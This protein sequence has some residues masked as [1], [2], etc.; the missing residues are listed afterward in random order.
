MILFWYIVREF[1]RY[2]TGTVILSVFLFL[3]FD[4]V[5]RATRFFTVYDATATEVILFYLYQIPTLITQIMPIAG[6]IA[7]VTC[8]LLLAR[9]NEITA[10]RAAGM[11]PFK[12]GLPI[13]VGGILLSLLECV[14]SEFVVP[15]SAA[16]MHYVKEVL[17]EGDSDADMS[18]KTKWLKTPKGFVY[19]DDFN[20]L[21]KVMSGIKII[22]TN[23]NFQTM[24]T[25]QAK[26]ATY[27]N[28]LSAWE[29]RDTILTRYSFDGGVAEIERL[30]TV[31]I[32]LPTTNK[33]LRRERR[34][35][36][37][38]SSFELAQMMQLG[39]DAGADV[40]PYAADF[41]VKIALHFAAFLVSLIGIKYAY[42]SER[43]VES[44]ASILLAITV[45]IGYWL[46]LGA[47]RTIASKGVA[48][49]MLA[50]WLA[51]VFVLSIAVFQIWKTQHH[52][53]FIK[54]KTSSI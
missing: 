49:P 25:K 28:L 50:A 35:P 4:A 47:A 32:D 42:Q 11:G 18:E 31:M 43:K 40:T 36:R 34:D 26:T 27:D 33:A 24:R 46:I 41:H 44:A 23:A 13:A 15:H 14:V 16:K 51:N 20:P 54:R 12:V 7:S 53:H 52:S 6:L 22:E 29:L 45:G 30:N 19:F 10:M 48:P 39:K 5:H 17:I 3:L 1:F 21:T 2:V 9:T 38:M 8:M 37:E